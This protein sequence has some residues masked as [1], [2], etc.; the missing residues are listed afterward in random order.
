MPVRGIVTHAS[1]EGFQ[2][3]YGT[4]WSAVEHYLDDRMPET[5]RASLELVVDPAF[6]SAVATTRLLAALAKRA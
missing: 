3:Q 5:Q 4:L 6:I 1:L 2:V